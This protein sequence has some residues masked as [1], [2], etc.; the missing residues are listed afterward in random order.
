MGRTVSTLH[1]SIIQLYA[2]VSNVQDSWEFEDLIDNI[3]YE[4]RAKYKSMKR[5]FNHEGE[6]VIICENGLVE[7]GISEY[8][9]LLSL[10][11]RAKE[12]KVNPVAV[13]AAINMEQHLQK[14]LKEYTSGCYTLAGV[15]S[16][17]EGVYS[18]IAD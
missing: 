15:F 2:D 11:V 13:R 1:G 3:R 18:K 5:S 8:C 10:S 12:G 9:G 7:I 4:I 14:V 17:G 16:N 6:N